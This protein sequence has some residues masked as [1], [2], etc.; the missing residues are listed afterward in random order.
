MG[1]F[2]YAW[3]DDYDTTNHRKIIE[4]SKIEEKKANVISVVKEELDFTIL[5]SIDEAD[6]EEL[7]A[8]IVE[9][10]SKIQLKNNQKKYSYFWKVLPN[11]VVGTTVLS[12]LGGVI[13][14]LPFVIIRGN[15]TLA[16]HTSNVVGI[17]T[18]FWI[19]YHRSRSNV[20]LEKFSAGMISAILGAIIALVTIILG[21]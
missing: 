18:M 3:E 12:I 2:F 16:I 11:Y 9:Y 20:F 7:Y 17:L 13:V 6:R 8:Q 4:D 10:L 14:L 21:G 19:G 5:E 1:G 15:L